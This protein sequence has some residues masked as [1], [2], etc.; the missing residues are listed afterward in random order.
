MSAV[1]S[2]VAFKVADR[3]KRGYGVEVDGATVDTLV[4]L[5]EGATGNPA[6][7]VAEWLEANVAVKVNHKKA[8][9]VASQIAH[10]VTAV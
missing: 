2:K 9:H 3:V 7:P 1:Q 8:V 4:G 10:D 6:H 5:V